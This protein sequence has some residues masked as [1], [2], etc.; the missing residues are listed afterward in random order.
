MQ[1]R[2]ARRRG[3]DGFVE[4]SHDSYCLAVGRI[5]ANASKVCDFSG[6]PIV[7][8]SKSRLNRYRWS[9][10]ACTGSCK[11]HG[12]E[13]GTNAVALYSLILRVRA[14]TVRRIAMASHL[15][16]LGQ[17]TAFRFPATHGRN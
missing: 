2:A 16:K 7:W 6:L 17:P 3:Q 8:L 11:N 5:N 15:D 9:I 14:D 1:P 4:P 10:A 12:I 13:E